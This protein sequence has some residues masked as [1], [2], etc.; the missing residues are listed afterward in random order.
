MKIE[1]TGFEGLWILQP[2]V[3]EDDRGFFME[4]FNQELYFKNN[5]QKNFVQDNQSHS[6]KNV[7]RGLHF[8]KPPFAQTKLVRVLYGVVLDVVVDLRKDQPTFGKTFFIEL[9]SE[10]KKQ[11]LIP[12][13]FAHGFSVLSETAGVFYKCDEYYHPEAD[14]GLHY[15]DRNLKIDWK[16][17]QP[18]EIVSLKD[19]SLPKLSELTSYF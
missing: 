13:G 4:S 6:V 17:K 14:A 15:N 18:N 3:F 11:V 2:K 12:K 8:Q 9:S 1:A 10:N 16:V 5:L 19:Q 7:I